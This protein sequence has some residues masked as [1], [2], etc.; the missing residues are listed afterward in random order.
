[1]WLPIRTSS[2]TDTPTVYPREP[3]SSPCL[4]T[5]TVGDE[6]RA[7]G[8]QPGKKPQ[9]SKHY[10]NMTSVLIAFKL[11]GLSAPLSL[12]AK[13]EALRDDSCNMVHA[14]IMV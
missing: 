11:D 1:M 4:N 9:Q 3:R 14:Y 10:E 6:P 8:I 7:S 2:L 12:A 13:M 5:Q